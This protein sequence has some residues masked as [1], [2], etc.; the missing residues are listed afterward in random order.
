MGE[1]KLITDEH[2]G[3]PAVN[4]DG[5]DLGGI[6]ESGIEDKQPGGLQAE[7]QGSVRI[8][9]SAD[10]GGD[11]ERDGLWALQGLAI[12]VEC[13]VPPIDMRVGGA[14][15]RE[16]QDEGGRGVQTDHEQLKVL[17]LTVSEGEG[18]LHVVGDVTSGGGATIKE[19]EVDG[20]GSSHNLAFGAFIDEV[21]LLT[22]QDAC[23][24][25]LSSLL[26][27]LWHVNP[28]PVPKPTHAQGLLIICIV[29]SGK[30]VLE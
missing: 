30:G 8:V 23:L 13:E 22:T 2:S 9:S 16:A 17:P 4:E 15:P 19:D 28:W 20:E 3:G 6:A 29:W 24:L 25:M 26:H 21:T 7:L 11:I 12:K 5:E 1:V 14:E 27:L 18:G 10:Q